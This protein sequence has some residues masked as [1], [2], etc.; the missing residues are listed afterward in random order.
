MASRESRVSIRCPEWLVAAALTV[1]I[2][3]ALAAGA[4]RRT[5]QPAEAW[6]ALL[7]TADRL[8][9]A[10]PTATLGGRGLSARQGYLLA[11][12]EA[13]DAGDVEHMLAVA[14]RLD[15]LSEPDLAARVRRA[16]DRVLGEIGTRLPPAPAP[17]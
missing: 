1:A 5:G 2:G 11:F 12:H 4:S 10:P 14:D 8:A 6:T 16:V 15:A 7:Q 9:I 3:L 13:L 17:G